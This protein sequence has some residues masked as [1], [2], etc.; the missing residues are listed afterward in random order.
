MYKGKQYNSIN[1]AFVLRSE[2][3]I[4]RMMNI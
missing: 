1:F 2:H 3:L 4:R